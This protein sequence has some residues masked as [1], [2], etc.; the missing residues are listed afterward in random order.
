MKTHST[1]LNRS[2]SNLKFILFIVGLIFI[3]KQT[4]FSQKGP[5]GVGTTDGT[6][7]LSL[8]L[9]AGSISGIA[10]NANMTGTWEDLSGNGYDA[11]IGSAPQYKTSG[12][13]NNQPS[14]YFDDDD[15][16]FMIVPENSEIM[17][18]DEVSIFVA[19][20]FEN[21]SDQW[22]SIISSYDD[23]AGNDGWAFERNGGS[24]N[25]NFWVDDYTNENCFLPMTY[26][27]NEVWS[28]VFNTTD[29][30]GYAYLSEN[31]C[32]FPFNG[33]MDYHGG[34]N[35]DLLIGA[36]ADDGGPGY[37][38]RG[39]ICEVIVYD[40][41]V[42][43]AQRIIISNYLAA[44]YN[45]T[46]NNFDIYNEDDNGDYDFDVSGIGRTDASNIQDDSQGSGMLRIFNPTN[47][48]NDE[49]M[50]WGHNNGTTNATNTTDIPASVDA[51]L[52]RVW[53]IS[54][55]N[56]N[57]TSNVNV[58]SVDIQWDLSFYPTPI[59]AS[60]LALL[61]DTDNDGSFTDESPITGAT[62]LGGDVYQF[63][64]VPGGGAGLRNDR[65]FTLATT[66]LF[67]TP[68]PINL[69]TFEAM[70]NK[71]HVML[72][73][74]TAQ[75]QNND[76]FK[77]ERLSTTNSWLEIAKIDGAGNSTNSRTYTFNDYNPAIGI[78]YYRL[79]Q[80]DFNGTFTY[81][82]V[83]AVHIEAAMEF[84]C[85]PNP[86][87]GTITAIIRNPQDVT[88]E[89]YATDGKVLYRN[90]TPSPLGEK[91]ILKESGVFLIVCSSRY[92]RI[93]KRVI[94]LD[95]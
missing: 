89:V 62:H 14:L 36:G 35:D 30:V 86:S 10:N 16:E 66:N 64:S 54:E 70:Q 46:L 3:G 31:T 87:N 53:R 27:Q 77:L 41:A 13:G 69:L 92:G 34:A 32:S 9:D 11:I 78:N 18:T 80:T 26:N 19:A 43:D 68:L 63:S 23:N 72:R 49:F 50:I 12:G 8:W 7:N 58:G 15:N 75:E 33:P 91:I 93:S 85:Y 24:N 22:A 61:I 28:M 20:N 37:F 47:L 38:M 44:K 84:S 83:K 5:G 67:Q 2:S 6:S 1:Y 21:G 48:G 95:Y 81:S 40:V 56:T 60:D 57:N 51:R 88:L 42:N 82:E 39:D 55:R 17:P 74:V 29:N 79:K 52:D 4:V 25:M 65:R 94:V 90:E 76:F 71:D 59:T 73:W 45:I